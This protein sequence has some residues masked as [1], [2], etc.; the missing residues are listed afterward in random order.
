MPTL[1][2]NLRRLR[3]TRK[4]GEFAAILGL[5]QASYSRYESGGRKPD[6]ETLYQM[7]TALG[8]SV[9]HLLGRETPDAAPPPPLAAVPDQPSTPCRYPEA[10]D[11]P[12]EL[13]DV[14]AK[15]A[16]QGEQLANIQTLLLSLLAEERARDTAATPALPAAKAS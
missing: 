6:G 11:L 13:A 3:G 15:L 2:E 4:Q 16:A 7:A 5:G 14:R 9:G 12:A 8:V 1:P 10:C